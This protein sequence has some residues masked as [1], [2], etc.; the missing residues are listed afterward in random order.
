MC[1][2]I[3]HKEQN[4]VTLQILM[5]WTV[6][7][8]HF[9]FE[10][11]HFGSSLQLTSF[12]W[13]SVDGCIK[14]YTFFGQYRKQEQSLDKYS[15]VSYNDSLDIRHVNKVEAPPEEL[16]PMRIAHQVASF[17]SAITMSAFR[18]RNTANAR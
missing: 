12:N 1:S 15:Y 17:V 11:V 6:T 5:A 14:H 4:C 18:D 8:F 7:E 2:S 10:L 16:L 13:D 9:V 3:E